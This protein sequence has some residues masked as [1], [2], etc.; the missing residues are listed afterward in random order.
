MMLEFCSGHFFFYVTVIITKSNF[1][2][3]DFMYDMT[4][5]AKLF[6]LCVLDL[7]MSQYKKRYFKYLCFVTND[8]ILR[9]Y[10]KFI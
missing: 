2:N 8:F 1:F 9:F 4:Y 5:E 3:F 10:K 6:H 7:S